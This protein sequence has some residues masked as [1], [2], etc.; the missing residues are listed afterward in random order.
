[1]VSL[2]IVLIATG[3]GSQSEFVGPAGSTTSSFV[4]SREEFDRAF[5]DRN[6]FYTYDDLVAALSAYPA[7]TTTGDITTRRREAAAFL[8]NI[9]HE[10]SG[11]TLIVEKNTA[12][13][14][15]YCDSSKPYGCPA[16]K[17]AYFGRGPV[18]LSWNYN[19][20]GAGKAIGVDLLSDPGRVQRD[21]TVAWKTSLW[22]WNT[23]AAAASVTPHEAMVT[24]RGFGETIRAF[25]GKLEC[26]GG[27]P[28]QV[29]SRVES[30]RRMTAL[31]G[32]TPG[33]NLSC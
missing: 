3:C 10:T 30:Y 7:F 26:D 24:D 11:L 20:L 5:P 8:A 18:Q 2:V 21:A 33:G 28:A 22:F 25:N 23:Q 15:N 13:Y 29:R 19:Y 14:A 31:L 6:P 4:V 17:A 1:M 32:V 27:N 9:D 16:G 12:N